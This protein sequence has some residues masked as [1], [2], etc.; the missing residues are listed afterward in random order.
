MDDRLTERD[1]VDPS[2]ADD[3]RA[4]IRRMLDLTPEQRIIGLVKAAAFF[5]AARRV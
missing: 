1:D 4:L 5:A 3:E 2:P